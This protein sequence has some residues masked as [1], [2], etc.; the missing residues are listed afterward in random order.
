MIL[1]IPEPGVT[2]N[3]TSEAPQQQTCCS[4]LNKDEILFHQHVKEAPL[5]MLHKIFQSTLSKRLQ[6]PQ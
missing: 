1:T 4:I 5:Q 3:I 2:L 6:S